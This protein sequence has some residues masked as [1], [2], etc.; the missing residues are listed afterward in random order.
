MRRR[1][2]A[3]YLLTTLLVLLVLEIPLGLTVAH[4][5][6]SDLGHALRTDA[7]AAAA[8][9]EQVLDHG[10]FDLLQPLVASYRDSTKQGRLLIVDTSGKVLADSTPG[11]S[12]AGDA[13]QARPEIAAALAGQAVQGTRY[14]SLLHQ[15]LT[16]V[17]LP[18]RKDGVVEA[19]VR[20]SYPTSYVDMRVRRTWLTLIDL[21][22]IVLVLVG[23][24]GH[25]LARTVVR[26]VQEIGR[27]A[28]ALGGGD[29][30]ARA[31]PVEGPREVVE[32][33]ASFDDT[34]ARLER[35]VAAQAA[36]A[37]HASHQLRTP[38]TVLRMRLEMLE[39]GASDEDLAVAQSELARLERLVDALLADAVQGRS[40]TDARVDAVAAVRARI[41]ALRPL[42]ES[43][44]VA[45]SG[46]AHDGRV[47]V[48]T[49]AGTLATVLDNL[50]TNALEASAGGSIEI[51][52]GTDPRDGVITVLDRGHGLG[53]GSRPG[54][55][56]LGLT[57]VRRLVDSA[58]G[59]FRLAN[60]PG[61]GA[62]AQVR[63]PLAEPEGGSADRAADPVARE[64]PTVGS[65][66]AGPTG[67]RERCPAARARPAR[68]RRR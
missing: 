45:L 59:T 67:S 60:R 19:A 23:L 10:R 66:P 4:L 32:L 20:I 37:G 47:L 64:A 39:D 41:D 53:A 26:P 24:L 7:D 43:H 58:G 13:A 34:A 54:G 27:A 38:L 8:A 33:A 40:A 21:G 46:P 15:R 1:L 35:L 11:E 68:G 29:L 44:G 17:A 14:S 52:V 28:R 3:S 57:V 65:G 31:G 12:D 48:A 18:V 50:V 61:G 56:G 62:V 49:S 22:L 25:V 6:R 55:H 2:T 9:V 36:F 51:E 16:F 30:T 5:Q 63:L 42:A